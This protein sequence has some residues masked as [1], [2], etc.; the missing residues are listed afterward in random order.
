VDTADLDEAGQARVIAGAVAA[1]KRVQHLAEE[2][3]AA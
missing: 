1:F 3:Y 2:A